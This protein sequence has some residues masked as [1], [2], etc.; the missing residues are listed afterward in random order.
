LIII[1][2]VASTLSYFYCSSIQQNRLVKISKQSSVVQGYLAQ[3][4]DATYSIWKSG[5]NW[6]VHWYDPASM[7]PHIVNILIDGA[8][9]QIIDVEE[10]E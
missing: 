2:V 4:P 5:N 6:I 9:L 1:V 10:A 7:I 3:H 8:T